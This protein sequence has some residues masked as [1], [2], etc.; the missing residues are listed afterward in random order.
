MTLRTQNVYLD[1]IHHYLLPSLFVNHI[2]RTNQI[3]YYPSELLRAPE[4]KVRSICF[5]YRIR[6]H[7]CQEL[8]INFRRSCQKDDTD[9]KEAGVLWVHALR[10]MRVVQQMFP[11]M[12]VDLTLL[13]SQEDLQICK[14][15]LSPAGMQ[16]DDVTAIIR[17]RECNSTMACRTIYIDEYRYEVGFVFSEALQ[18][19]RGA[20]ILRGTGQ[21]YYYLRIAMLLVFCY[22]VTPSNK[23]RLSLTRI[24]KAFVLFMKAPIQS[25]IFGSPFPIFCYACAHTIDASTSYE[26]LGNIFNTAGGVFELKFRDL[27]TVGFNQMRSVWLLALVLHTFILFA[28]SR[29]KLDWAPVNGIRGVPEFLLSGLSSVTIMAQFRST[30]F[31]NAKIYSIYEIAQ[32]STLQTIRARQ[33]TTPRGSGTIQLGGIFIDFKIFACVLAVFCTFFLLRDCLSYARWLRSRHKSRTPKL[34]TRTPVSY[35]AGVLWPIGSMC[36]LWTSDYFCVKSRYS[37]SS[38]NNS[39]KN[40]CEKETDDENESALLRE[41]QPRERVSATGGRSQS[42]RS[43]ASLQNMNAR[44]NEVMEV[45]P[46]VLMS[47]REFRSIQ[48][49]MESLHNRGDD[50]EATVAFMNLVTMSDPIVYFCFILSGGGGKTLGYYQSLRNREKF[51]LLPQDA[52]GSADLRAQDLKLVCSVR[53]PALQL[54]DLIHCG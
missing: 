17:V 21:A 4:G 18:W 48:H 30:Y 19:Y 5:D 42:R 37:S 2:W 40:E 51:F 15:G 28:T 22:R 23:T 25:V 41:T 20:A 14:G 52:I 10:R 33:N 31:R 44:L 47:A 43:F 29:R 35:S 11:T 16:K 54:T 12:Q 24:K 9:C 36:V 34:Q 3:F 45:L 6:P 53:S 27:L 1:R 32:S 49:Q 26:I 13:E 7:F 39:T 50:V 38:K 8:W 46:S